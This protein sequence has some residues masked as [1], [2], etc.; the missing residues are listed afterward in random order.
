MDALRRQVAIARRRL[1]VQ[2]FFGTLVWTLFATLMTAA[3][4]IAVQKWFLPDLD[5]NQWA[6]WWSSGALSVGLLAATAWTWIIRRRDFDAAF[7]IDRRFGLQSRV[8]SSLALATDELETPFGRALLS[9]TLRQVGRIDVGEKF[10][11]VLGRHSWLPLVPAAV[12]AA[13][14]VF[15]NPQRSAEA[16]AKADALAVKKQ[17]DE[18]IKP[19]AK[20]FADRKQEA[21]EQ[22]LKEAE[23]LFNKLEQ[24]TRDLKKRDGDRNRALA[25]LNDLAKELENRREKLAA[26]E[27][28]KQQLAQMKNM[29]SGPAEQLAQALKTGNFRRAIQELEHLKAQL[30]N[31][32][33][34]PEKQIALADQ[35]N[36]MKSALQKMADAQKKIEA[37]LQQQKEHAEKASDHVAAQK[38]QNRLDKFAGQKPR[39]DIL[40]ELANQLGQC[41]QCMKNGDGAKTQ[42]NLAELAKQLGEMERQAAEMAMLDGAL[43]EIQAAKNAMVCKHCDGQGC[44]ECQGSLLAS[45]TGKGRPSKGIGRGEGDWGPRPEGPQESKTYDSRVR[46]SVGKGSAVVTGL[47]HGPNV[48]G[49]VLEDIKSQVEAAKHDQSDPLT[50]QRLPRQQRDHVQQYFDAFRSGK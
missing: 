50:D 30:A 33:L 36:A 3:V 26:G 41:A 24:G 6:M 20:K 22:R 21:T 43:D 32:K 15:F 23:H 14:F 17:I 38:L 11:V 12:A 1:V 2:Q 45:Q 4:A 8:A 10:P 44:K 37:A 34:A 49:A 40:K 35:M 48:K 46:S 16:Q 39:M 27:R 25:K 28:L 31:S 42:A 18:S 7:E 47:V 19:L 13:L 5:A 9:D 29:S